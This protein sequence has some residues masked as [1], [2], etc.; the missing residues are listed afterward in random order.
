M[1]C[2]D[3]LFYYEYLVVLF[4]YFTVCSVFILKLTSSYN[5]KSERFYCCRDTSTFILFDSFILINPEFQ[6]HKETTSLAVHPLNV[7]FDT[8]T[9]MSLSLLNIGWNWTKLLATKKHSTD[10]KYLFF[11]F[12][13]Q[14]KHDVLF[15]RK[16]NT[17][18]V[19]I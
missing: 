14:M 8:N 17:C 10:K 6:R 13:L 16:I 3:S 12:L 18:R 1:L 4:L 2:E 15:K 19:A 11:S 9:S 5:L 7:P